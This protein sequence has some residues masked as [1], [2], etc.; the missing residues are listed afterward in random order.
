M[1]G[2]TG[3]SDIGRGIKK[4]SSRQDG[5]DRDSACGISHHHVRQIDGKQLSVTFNLE[6]NQVYSL[7][8]EDRKSPWMT[9]AADRFRF[10]R[11]IREV[12]QVLDPILKTHIHWTHVW[13]L[14]T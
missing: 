11:R 14:C 3:D 12:E 10:Q 9:V 1:G 5:G 2:I 7:P 8:A 13:K 6:K 4:N